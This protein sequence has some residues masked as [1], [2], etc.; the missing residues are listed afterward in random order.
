MFE[1]KD[2]RFMD[3]G[4]KLKEKVSLLRIMKS[5]ELKNSAML[6]RSLPKIRIKS[7]RS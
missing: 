2:D 1:A 6:E 4:R 5:V 7:G 3:V